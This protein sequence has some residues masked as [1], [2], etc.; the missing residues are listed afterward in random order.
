MTASPARVAGSARS[1][2]FMVVPS[3]LGA[4]AGPVFSLAADVRQLPLHVLSA[5]VIGDAGCARAVDQAVQL[6]EGAARV[7][8]QALD[9]VA[10]A[11][12]SAAGAYELA[13]LVA[14][15]SARR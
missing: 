10:R 7:S 9:E 15:A 6:V 12:R 5:D 2:P 8:A 3:S 14:V 11:L 1:G 13:D 4:A